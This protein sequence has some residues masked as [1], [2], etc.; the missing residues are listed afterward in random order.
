MRIDDSNNLTIYL[1]ELKFLK[2]SS[3]FFIRV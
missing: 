2:V 1:K 3:N